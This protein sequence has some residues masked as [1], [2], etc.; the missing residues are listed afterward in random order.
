VRWIPVVLYCALITWLSS[1][2]GSELPKY[3]W[4]KYDKVL[5]AMEYSGL[6]FLLCCALKQ[7]HRG[8]RIGV[9][10]GLGLLFGVIDEFHQSFVAGR[11]GNDLGDMTADLV[12]STL[13]AIAF[14]VLAHLMQRMRN[15][16]PA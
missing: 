5:H 3:E 11:Q 10:I 16:E 15:K 7:L 4:M 13:G 1:H 14:V 2:S 8:A 12:G 9:S 6:G